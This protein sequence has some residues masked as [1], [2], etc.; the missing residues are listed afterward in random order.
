MRPLMNRWLSL[1]SLPIMQIV[2]RSNDTCTAS[3]EAITILFF[4][5]APLDVNLSL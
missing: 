4:K 5:V 3:T 2:S 1:Q